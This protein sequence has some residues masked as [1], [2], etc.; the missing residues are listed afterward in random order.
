MAFQLARRTRIMMLVVPVLPEPVSGNDTPAGVNR[1]GRLDHD[2]VIE[3][4]QPPVGRPNAF[5][6]VVSAQLLRERYDAVTI[7]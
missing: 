1:A 6:P 5:A 3:S 4:L 7:G 2:A